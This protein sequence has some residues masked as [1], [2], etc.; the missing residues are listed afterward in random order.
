MGLFKRRYITDRDRR[1]KHLGFKMHAISDIEK[2]RAH[3]FYTKEPE[4][5]VWIDGFKPNSIFIDVGANIGVYSL[6]CAQT[7]PDVQVYAFEPMLA[8]FTRLVDNIGLNDPC[9]ITPIN[10][11][12]GKNVSLAKFFVKN[13][14]VGESGSQIYAPIDEN[15]KIIEEAQEKE[16]LVATFDS[17]YEMI[18]YK[19]PTYLKIDVDGRE[20]DVLAGIKLHA[21]AL[22]GVLVEVN[23]D[24]IGVSEVTGKMK[25]MGLIPDNRINHMKPHSSQ[26]RGGNPVNIVFTRR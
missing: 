22:E 6:Y 24:I 23:T 11:G 8:N 16:V 21:P 25:A 12:M 20:W 19:R 13:D 2:Y 4:T 3:T 5:L 17:F 9:N 18:P 26:R 14:T 1:G 15:G 7:K 10:Q